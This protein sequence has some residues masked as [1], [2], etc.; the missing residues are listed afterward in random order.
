VALRG[1]GPQQGRQENSLGEKDSTSVAAIEK[2]ENTRDTGYDEGCVNK[3][4]P[5]RQTADSMEGP[6]DQENLCSADWRK[7]VQ[8][9]SGAHVQNCIS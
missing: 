8:E 6:S 3:A 5:E 2:V 9:Q 1:R 7:N 4:T